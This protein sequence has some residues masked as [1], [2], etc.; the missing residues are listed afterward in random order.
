MKASF[1]KSCIGQSRALYEVLLMIIKL[2][3]TPSQKLKSYLCTRLTRAHA[4]PHFFIVQQIFT[5][6]LLQDQLERKQPKK[7]T[8]GTTFEAATT[9]FP[10][11]SSLFLLPPPSSFISFFFV[12]LEIELRAS[13]LLAKFS[14]S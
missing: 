6:Y 13:H 2:A 1:F 11:L 5:W 3:L 12:A 4:S 8:T 9:L 10:S 14:T 7:Q